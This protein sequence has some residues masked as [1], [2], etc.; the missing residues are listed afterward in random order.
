MSR[1]HPGWHGQQCDCWWKRAEASGPSTSATDSEEADTNTLS[2]VCNR[3]YQRSSPWMVVKT[4]NSVWPSGTEPNT[5]CQLLLRQ[6][7]PGSQR[8]YAGVDTIHICI[9][10]QP[11][12][13]SHIQPTL[14]CS[15]QARSLEE[16]FCI[17][18][19]TVPIVCITDNTDMPWSVM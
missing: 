4:A 1:V 9:M 17:F 13:W 16:Y 11:G 3:S 8:V 7:D 6:A 10:R 18:V 12:A 19:I 14:T 15:W 2:P 5:L